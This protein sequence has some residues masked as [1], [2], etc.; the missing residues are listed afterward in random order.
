[1]SRRIRSIKPEIAEDEVAIG[2]SDAAW[3][4]WVTAW[5][6][7]D[8]AGNVR[9]GVRYL[10]ASVWQDTTRDA[11]TPLLELLEKGRFEP[12]SVAGQHYAHI[13]AWDRHQRIDNAAKAH[14]PGQCDDD[15]TW[16]QELSGIFAAKRRQ[17][18]LYAATGG[19]PPL[20]LEG[21]G[22][23]RIGSPAA[24]AAD[25][26]KISR[27]AQGSRSTDAASRARGSRV[28]ENWQPSTELEAWAVGKGVDARQHRDEFVDHYLSLP[29]SKGSRA[30]WNATFR[31]WIH[32][33]IEFGT[34]KPLPNYHR[35]TRSA[36]GP[37]PALVAER[38]KFELVVQEL[39]KGPA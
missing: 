7:A 30:N 18:P 17:L 23:D 36:S 21:R 12:Y 20:D 22:E 15:G 33:A 9:A 25:S 35:A 11:R 24:D 29:G 31:S 8:D 37:D 16:F 10:A 26:E 1:M 6:L 38:E 39:G 19:D 3:R 13:H 28:P 14:V 34:A 27:R 5:V 4:M 2:L 32:K